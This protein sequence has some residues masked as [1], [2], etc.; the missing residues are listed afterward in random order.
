MMLAPLTLADDAEL[1]RLG[2]FDGAVELAGLASDERVQRAVIPGS[3]FCPVRRGS[4]RR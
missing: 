4:G 1:G 3:D 2:E